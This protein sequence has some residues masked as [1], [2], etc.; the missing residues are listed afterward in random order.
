MPMPT[1]SALPSVSPDPKPVR[2]FCQRVFAHRLAVGLLFVAVGVFLARPHTLWGEYRLWGTIASL[3]VIAAGLGLRFWAAG[4]AGTHTHSSAIEGPQLA[5]GGPYAFARNPIYLGSMIA[6]L[7]MI[8]LIGDARLLPLHIAAFAV[9]YAIIVPAEERYLQATFGAEYERY[10]GAVPRFLPR[11]R[12]W[13]GRIER[14]FHWQAA[15]GELRLL[16]V[17]VAIYAALELGAWARADGQP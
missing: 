14:G 7:G 1:D 17:F 16:G 2:R 9:L 6:G 15:R 8:G 13:A 11:L 3:A 5:T 4:S 12:P 10:R